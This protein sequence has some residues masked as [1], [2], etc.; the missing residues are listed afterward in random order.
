MSTMN[1]NVSEHHSSDKAK[2][3][4]KRKASDEAPMDLTCDDGWEEVDLEDATEVRKYLSREVT[5]VKLPDK[6]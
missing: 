1:L 2:A 4:K 3:N 6:V 5:A